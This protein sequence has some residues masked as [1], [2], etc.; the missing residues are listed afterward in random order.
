MIASQRN[1]IDSAGL[2]LARIS[3]EYYPDCTLSF[4]DYHYHYHYHLTH[5]ATACYSSPFTESACAVIQLALARF[6]RVLLPEILG[7]T[8]AY[9]QAPTLLEVCFPNQQQALPFFKL[10]KQ[11][12]EQ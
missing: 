11:L 2:N 7:F 12:T 6:P 3:V 10:H 5:A 9:S 4:V 8:L 1:N